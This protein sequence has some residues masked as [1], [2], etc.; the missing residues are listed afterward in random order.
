MTAC[1]ILPE[2]ILYEVL[3][4]NNIWIE[5]VRQSSVTLQPQVS[6][7]KDDDDC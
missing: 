7:K 2:Y 4:K 5:F 6:A 3:D 1:A